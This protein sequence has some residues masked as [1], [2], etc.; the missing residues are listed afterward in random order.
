MREIKLRYTFQHNETRRIV[1]VIK[2]LDDEG[3]YLDHPSNKWTLLGRNQ[4]IGLHDKNGKEIYEEGDICNAHHPDEYG[5]FVGYIIWDNEQSLYS[6]RT[7]ICADIRLCQF[8]EIEIIGNIYNNTIPGWC[9]LED[10]VA[11]EAELCTDC[12][13]LLS[14]GG[15]SACCHASAA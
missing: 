7:K 6:L 12:G 8:D 1:S 14:D 3:P 10:V 9:E 2:N 15:H 11:A 13:R 4:Y 5:Y